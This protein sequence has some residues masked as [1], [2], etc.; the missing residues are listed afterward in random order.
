MAGRGCRAQSI[1][2]VRKSDLGSGKTLDALFRAGRAFL[3]LGFLSFIIFLMDGR[4]RQFS[5]MTAFRDSTPPP[6]PRAVYST[7]SLSSELIYTITT[8][9]LFIETKQLDIGN[10]GS[11]PNRDISR[12]D[13]ASP[14]SGSCVFIPLLVPLP[15]DPGSRRSG[16]CPV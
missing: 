14:F 2:A 4:V 6:R 15:L 3:S 7:D 9:L 5:R 1:P 11:R 8:T 13:P 16:Y 10:R 12:R